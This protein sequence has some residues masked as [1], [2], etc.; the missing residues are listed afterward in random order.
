MSADIDGQPQ[1]LIGTRV[2]EKASKEIQRPIERPLKKLSMSEIGPGK[3]QRGILEF[4]LYAS[5]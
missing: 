5:S 1:H 4:L 2:P 3:S